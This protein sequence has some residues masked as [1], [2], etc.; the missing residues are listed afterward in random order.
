MGE[1][2]FSLPVKMIDEEGKNKNTRLYSLLYF[3]AMCRI[4][5]RRQ[6]S[7]QHSPSTARNVTLSKS[8]SHVVSSV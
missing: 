8:L 3:A 5:T 6:Y 2:K 4:C 1:T 7:R